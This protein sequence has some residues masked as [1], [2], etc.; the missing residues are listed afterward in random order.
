MKT[1]GKGITHVKDLFAKYT[2]NLIAPQKTVIQAFIQATEDILAYS[3]DP[4]LCN[5]SPHTRT[6][7]VRCSGI[8]K[9]EIVK[10]KKE[11]LTAMEGTLG[12]KNVPK[13]IL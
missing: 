6:L 2:Q 9:T 12:A 13:N 1:R 10:K 11:I 8:V 3:V 7:S 4:A 5:Y